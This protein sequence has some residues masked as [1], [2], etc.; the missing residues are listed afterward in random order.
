M[1]GTIINILTVTAGSFVGI[2]IHKRLPGKI[3]TIAFQGI[4]LFTIVLG[5]SM[6]LKTTS[7]LF[8]VISIVS[9]AIL[10]ELIDID[11]HFTRLSEFLKKKLKFKNEKFSEGFI[12]AFLLFCMGSMTIIGAIEE[13]LGGTPE[14]LLAKSVL[15]GTAA[16]ALA[17]TLGIGVL[18]SIVPLFIYQG[19]L[20]LLAGLIGPFFSDLIILELS[21]VGGIMLI[22][23]GLNILEL[24][25]IKIMNMLPA[26]III[27][28]LT[29]V[30]L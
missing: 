1:L 10:G 23:L 15:D 12:T 7:Y 21:A 20:T 18:F 16:V 14:L 19:G 17:A 25:K 8:M 2:L 22:G 9:G 29:G 30:F 24:K 6:A 4:G 26:L 13:G 3:I 28:I 27:V 5:L 11:R